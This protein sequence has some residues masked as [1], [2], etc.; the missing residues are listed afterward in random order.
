MGLSID[1]AH[2]EPITVSIGG[3]EYK[4]GRVRVCDLAALA[5]RLRDLRIG[6]VLRHQNRMRNNAMVAMAV[7]HAAAI[8][9]DDEEIWNYAQCTEGTKFLMWCAL[10]QHQPMIQECEVESLMESE[11]A[12]RDLL[13]TESGLVKPV[14]PDAP[15]EGEQENPTPVVFGQP[16][17][18]TTSK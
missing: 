16:A 14:S 1:K 8:D 4:M 11:S 15:E 9:P 2:N 10:R 6:A 3:R 17:E 18:D 5:E 13:Y 12:L 7:A